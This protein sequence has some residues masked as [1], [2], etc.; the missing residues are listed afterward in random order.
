[1]KR[2]TSPELL[3]PLTDTPEVSLRLQV[4]RGLRQAIQN[5][6]LRAGT[7]LPSSRV[8]AGDLGIS[9]G[10]VIGAYEQLLAEGYLNAQRGSATRVAP[11][12]VES[13]APIVEQTATPP[14]FAFDFRP[15]VPD[16]SLFPRRAWSSSL[17]RTIATAPDLALD[18]PDPAGALPARRA[19]AAYLNRVRAAVVQPERVI[20]TNGVSQGLRLVCQ[21]LH[22]RGVR[23]IAVEDPGHALYYPHITGDALEKIPVP[24]DADG[25]RVD[26]LE[27]TRAGAVLVTSAH[28]LP[29]GAVLAPH[30]RAALLDWA[31][32]RGATIIEDD[33]DAEY[34][35]DREPIGSL[36]GLAPD[37]VVYMGTASKT[38]SPALRLGWLVLP[39]EMV[40]EVRQAKRAADYGSPA[41]DQLALADFLDRGELDRHLRKTRLIYRARR[42]R[43]IAA[44]SSELP[45]L[46][47]QGVAAGLHLMIELSPGADE[48][49][50]VTAAGSRSIRL[51]PVAPFRASPGA[52]AL[53]LGYGALKE[54]TIPEAVGQLAS[55]LRQH[56]V[57]EM[58]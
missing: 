54:S 53:L 4:E 12:R 47:P 29:T 50:I 21:A 40:D 45:G 11:R 16:L 57:G 51:F 35:Y 44:L 31:F 24:V 34:R 26:L 20:L 8:L 14:S 2:A 22:A 38:L 19:L 41:L 52:P 46:K 15:G 17:R 27:R 56:D 32:Q 39:P 42:D 30:R 6:Q 58:T 48:E 23:S 36:Q 43:L 3:I 18:Y 25:L 28:Q 33:Y 10:V 7:A 37:H 1:M 9:R 5:G 13:K 55:L 49:K